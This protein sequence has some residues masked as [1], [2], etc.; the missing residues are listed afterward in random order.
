MHRRQK[1]SIWHLL[2]TF[3]RPT[4]SDE[5]FH[6]VIVR[7]EILVAQWPIF[8]V[9]VAARGLELVIA[10][11]ITFTRPAEGFASHLAPAYPHERL[12]GG[13]RV[14][15]LA[16]VHK[17]LVA[18][19]VARVTQPLNG[20]PLKQSRAVAKTAKLHLV[21]PDV[22][23]EVTRGQARRPGF[24]HEHAHSA[25]GEFFG[26]PAAT[27]SRADNQGIV[28]GWTAECHDV[29]APN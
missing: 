8:T 10:V 15:I 1:F 27:R 6:F 16:V 3:A 23:S 25:L 5:R 9:A 13:K 4:D 21:G 17:E 24:Q 14:G 18:I 20:L 29:R 22:F 19:S 26:D 7:F 2:E 28:N 12:V 11:A